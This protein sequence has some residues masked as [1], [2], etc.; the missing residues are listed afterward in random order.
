[1]RESSE[2][3]RSLILFISSK[4]L[5]SNLRTSFGVVFD[6]LIKPQPFLK[7]TLRPSI[8]IFSP[9]SSQ[10][11]SKSLIMENLVSSVTVIFNSGVE[12]D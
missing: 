7:L 3:K 8:V 1:M 11:S 2:R 12:N 5:P 4:E 10:L 6:A 9:S